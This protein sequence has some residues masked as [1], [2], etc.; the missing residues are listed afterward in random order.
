MKNTQSCAYWGARACK[1]VSSLLT[2]PP[3]T[4]FAYKAQRLCENNSRQPG[5]WVV[6]STWAMG[7]ELN[8]GSTWAMGGE[9]NLGDGW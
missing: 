9:L 3:Y 2:A 1:C 6:S 4:F 5:Q 8:L 7:G